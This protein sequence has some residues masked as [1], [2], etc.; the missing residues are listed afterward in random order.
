M[1]S[2]ELNLMG[3]GIVLAICL[4]GFTGTSCSPKPTTILRDSTEKRKRRAFE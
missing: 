1:G 2:A 4:F 3:V